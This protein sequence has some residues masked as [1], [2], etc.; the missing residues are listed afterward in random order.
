M[1]WLNFIHLYQPT[2]SSSYRIKEA[3]EKS[4]LRLTALL[5]SHKDLKFTANISACLLERLQEDAYSDLLKRWRQLISEGRLE[6]VGSAAYHAFLPFTPETEVIYQ[7]KKQEK[8]A[9]D[10]LGVDLSGGGFFLPEMAYT[11][12]LARLIKEQGYSWLI[13]DEAVLPKGQSYLPVLIDGNSDLRVVLRNRKLSNSYL[14]DIINQKGAK[15]ELPELIITA[16][17]AE[18]YGLR[19]EDPTGEL[20][21]MLQFSNLETKTIS[22]FLKQ[23]E[24]RDRIVL[25]AASWE[26]DWIRDGKE[27]F[28][29]WHDSSNKI[30]MDLWRL[31]DLAIKVGQK[32]PQDANYEWYRWHLDRGLASCMFW[33]ASARDFFH[34]FGPVA[35]SPD[36]VEAGLN[37]LMK[38]VRSLTSPETKS[39]K[40]KTEK[41]AN[42]I[43]RRLWQK[44]WRRHWLASV[45]KN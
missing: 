21:K 16:T 28:I 4:Y 32:F 9:Q 15:N 44:H 19:H 34:N 1:L 33:W 13:L 2:N 3:V 14:P 45:S 40:L 43:K 24:I 37:D 8:L 36:E 26:T 23:Q 41:I 31:A 38:A 17:D 7:I 22:E 11:P 18:L 30:Q 29:I 20:E 25:R 42:R 6:L 10:I 39:Y 35:W 5:E 27:P 12:E